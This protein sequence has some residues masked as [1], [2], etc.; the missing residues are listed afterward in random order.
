MPEP[1]IILCNYNLWFY[2]FRDFISGYFKLR[3]IYT[4][5]NL[6]YILK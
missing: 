4:K 1:M 2:K 5:R 6:Y 3:Y